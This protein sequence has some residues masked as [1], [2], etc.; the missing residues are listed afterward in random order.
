GQVLP[1]TGDAGHLRLSTEFALGADLARDARHF[2]CER[3]QLVHHRVDGVF[4]FENLPLHVDGDLARQVAARPGCGDF[5]DIV[6]LRGEVGGEQV[7]VV[8]QVFPGAADA[9]H[10]GLTAQSALGADF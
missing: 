7:D 5:G 2:A 6:D 4:Q 10:N 9:G 8:G 3:V 1:G